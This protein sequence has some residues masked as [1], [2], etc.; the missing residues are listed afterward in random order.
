MTARSSPTGGGE[1]KRAGVAPTRKIEATKK[2]ATKSRK[3]GGREKV[4][5]FFDDEQNYVMEEKIYKT[6][7]RAGE[8]WGWAGRGT[9][10]VEVR[11]AGA[12]GHG[13][14]SVRRNERRK[15]GRWDERQGKSEGEEEAGA[16]RKSVW[17]GVGK[18]LGLRRRAG[19]RES[20]R[21]S[22]VGGRGDCGAT[23]ANVNAKRRAARVRGQ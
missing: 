16:G 3:E 10:D 19:K 1:E 20:W 14:W 8:Q 2:Q 6:E 4:R 18:F 11:R 22:V 13:R 5:L 12:G 23:R 9:T 17:E 15:Y 21:G 7:R